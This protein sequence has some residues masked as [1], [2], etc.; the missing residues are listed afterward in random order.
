MRAQVVLDVEHLEA[1]GALKLVAGQCDH[2]I[3]DQPVK[4]RETYEK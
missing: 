3:T 1:V 2:F 4:L